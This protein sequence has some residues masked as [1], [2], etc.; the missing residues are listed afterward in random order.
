MTFKESSIVCRLLF[1]D[2]LCKN[3]EVEEQVEQPVEILYQDAMKTAMAA[4]QKAAPKFEEVERQH[5]Y[6]KLATR[7]SYNRMVVYEAN[8]YS[9]SSP[10]P[11]YRTEPCRPSHR[12]CYYQR[13]AFYEQIVDVERDAEMTRLALGHLKS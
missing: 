8:Q 1:A 6:S 9:R 7:A 3:P 5:P 4:S 2:K 10:G 11:V 12:I 13:C